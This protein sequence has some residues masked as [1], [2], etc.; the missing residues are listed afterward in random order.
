MAE[1]MNALGETSKEATRKVISG[2]KNITLSNAFSGWAKECIRVIC[3]LVD[4]QDFIWRNKGS[5]PQDGGKN[6]EEAKGEPSLQERFFKIVKEYTS[7]TCE[8]RAEIVK[9][10]EK[11]QKNRL[12]QEEFIKDT[13]KIGWEDDG[14]VLKMPDFKANK[15]TKFHKDVIEQLKKLEQDAKDQN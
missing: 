4:D 12:I 8:I 1:R 3:E 10:I 5:Q 7:I 9:R 15:F 13:F 14:S 2:E 11:C 6:L